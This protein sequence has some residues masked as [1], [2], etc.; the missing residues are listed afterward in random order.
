MTMV[1]YPLNVW[2]SKDIPV[3]QQNICTNCI[4]CSFQAFTAH[5]EVMPVEF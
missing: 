4:G 2:F 1:C 3:Y 5:V